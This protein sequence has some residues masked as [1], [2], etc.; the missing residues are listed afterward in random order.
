MSPYLISGTCLLSFACLLTPVSKQV[1]VSKQPQ[2]SQR[3]FANKGSPLSPSSKPA[4][5]KLPLRAPSARLPLLLS[6]LREPDEGRGNTKT[7][8]HT[9]RE[10]HT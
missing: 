9:R 6:S 5:I 2:V 7:I 1:L 4:D 10:M 3:G 8:T